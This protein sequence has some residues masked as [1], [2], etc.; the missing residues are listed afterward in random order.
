MLLL[1]QISVTSNTRLSRSKNVFS[2]EICEASVADSGK[3]T[4]R[5]KNQFG[6]CSA[7][8]SLHVHSKC[9]TLHSEACERS[10][11]LKCTKTHATSVK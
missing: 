2:L 6:Q 5:A 1:W 3:Y 11:N 10:D 7:T 8:A 9:I 4:V